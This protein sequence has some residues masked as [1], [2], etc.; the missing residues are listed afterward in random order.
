MMGRYEPSFVVV[1]KKY[2]GKGTSGAKHNNDSNG[3]VLLV[4]YEVTDFH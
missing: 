2:L 1:G 4:S 3:I